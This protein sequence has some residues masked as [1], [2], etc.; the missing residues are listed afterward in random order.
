MLVSGPFVRACFAQ[1]VREWSAPG[2][3]PTNGVDALNGAANFGSMIRL[4][5]ARRERGNKT[6]PQEPKPY[7]WEMARPKGADTRA[8][9]GA[10]LGA[11][12]E[13]LS[14]IPDI[15]AAYTRQDE[16]SSARNTPSIE[17]RFDRKAVSPTSPRIQTYVEGM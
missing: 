14:I 11:C 2:A 3:T 13:V 5:A 17:Q 7:E 15:P 8:N 6:P 12:R 9:G 4:N 10:H 16:P 1:Y